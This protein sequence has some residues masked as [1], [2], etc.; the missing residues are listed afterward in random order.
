MNSRRVPRHRPADS[1]CLDMA[2]ARGPE[3]NSSSAL[4]AAGLADVALAAPAKFTWC[5]KSCWQRSRNL[6]PDAPAQFH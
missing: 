4:T 3:R 2:A 5:R 1:L 6:D